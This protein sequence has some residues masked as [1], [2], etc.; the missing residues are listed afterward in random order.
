MI[1]TVFATAFTAVPGRQAR[2][3]VTVLIGLVATMAPTIGP[4]LGGYLTQIFSWHWLFLI[5]VVP[6]V[7][8]AIAVWPRRRCRPAEPQPAEG[9]RRASGWPLMAVFLGSLEY[10]LEEGPRDDWFD[11]GTIAHASPRSS[12]G[13]RRLF[14]WRVAHLPQPDRRPRAFADRNFAIGSLFSFMHRH[15]PLRLGLSDAAVPRR[16]ARLN[17]AADRR[18]ACSSPGSPSSCRRRSPAR[19]RTQA[20]PARAC[21]RSA[22]RCSASASGC[23]SHMTAESAFEELC[24]RRRCAAS[25]LMIVLDPGQHAGARHAAAGQAQERAAAS[26]T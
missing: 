19:C 24:G 23:I 5:N 4:T 20:R 2:R 15:R 16:G 3:H 11:D 17:S 6:G 25:A 21:W 10:V 14:F 9:L 1:P 26:T 18:D 8:V 13:R 12:R 22:S 7:I